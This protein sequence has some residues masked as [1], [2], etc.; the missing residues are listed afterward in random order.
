MDCPQGH[1]QIIGCMTL[2]FIARVYG[3][4]LKSID[5]YRKDIF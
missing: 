2:G 5:I 1:T 3:K 4:Y